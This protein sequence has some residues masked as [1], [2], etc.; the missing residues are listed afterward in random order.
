MLLQPSCEFKHINF[1]FIQT[2]I[3]FFCCLVFFVFLFFK[4]VGLPQTTTYNL[5]V[6]FS[7]IG[8]LSLQWQ[9]NLASIY[10]EFFQTS[11]SYCWTYTY[12]SSYFSIYYCLSFGSQRFTFVPNAKSIFPIVSSPKVSTRY[13]SSK[14]KSH[15]FQ[16]TKYHYQHHLNKVL[17]RL[18]W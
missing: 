3:G 4:N 15:Y 18:W 6:G 17:M 5:Q 10:Q 12:L 8:F 11:V 1:V 16:S 2:L 7:S 14:S 9:V 13:S